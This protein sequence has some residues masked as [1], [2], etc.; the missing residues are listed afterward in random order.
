[1]KG[2]QV[3][4]ILLLPLSS[5]ADSVVPI[6]KVENSVNIR[7]SPDA[8][9]DIVGEL[10]QGSSI[11]LVSSIDGWHEVQLEGD[12]TGYISAD[13]SRVVA[14]EAVVEEVAEEVVEEIVEEVEEAAEEV[15]TEVAAEA[16][17]DTPIVEEIVEEA[18]AGSLAGAHQ[19]P[20]EV[21]AAFGDQ[22]HRAI[23]GS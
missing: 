9:S 18:V 5:L 2:L 17:V 20:V 22:E 1:M 12:A 6:D 10:Y 8:S 7:L 3:L 14:D 13:W 16:L 11:E 4:W 15:V 23:A 21:N 19:S